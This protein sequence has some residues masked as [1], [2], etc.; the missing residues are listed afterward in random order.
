MPVKV[1]GWMSNTCCTAA[2]ILFAVA[3]YLWWAQEDGPGAAIDEP[4]RT[5]AAVTPGQ[6]TP[7]IY[8]LKNPTRHPV[9]VCG[10]A[11]C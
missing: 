4:E 10:L 9:R 7:V 3:F 5:L 8:Y 1:L 2:V 6:V 11:E